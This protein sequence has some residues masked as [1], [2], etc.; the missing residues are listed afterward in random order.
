MGG[1]IVSGTINGVTIGDRFRHGG[2]AK[3]PF[4]AEVVDIIEKVSTKTG[5]TVGYECHAKMIKQG[6]FTATNVFII[7]FATVVRNRVEATP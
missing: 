3:T 6:T 1:E 2:P 4:I 7:P 5:D